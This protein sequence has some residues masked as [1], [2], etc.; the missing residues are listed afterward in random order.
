MFTFRAEEWFLSEPFFN[1]C[2][3]ASNQ[4]GIAATEDLR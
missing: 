4:A 1:V 3:E 2:K